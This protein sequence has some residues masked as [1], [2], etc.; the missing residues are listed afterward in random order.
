MN[1]GIEMATRCGAMTKTEPRFL[2]AARAAL[3]LAWLLAPLLCG[4]ARTTEA[5]S[6]ET[7]FLQRCSDDCGPGLQ[8]VTQICTRTCENDTGCKGLG[9]ATS[10]EALP[11]SASDASAA[12]LA[13]DLVCTGDD[14]CAALASGFSCEAGR[15]RQGEST[16]PPAHDAGRTTDAASDVSAACEQGMTFPIHASDY[17]QSCERSSDC[18]GIGEGDGCDCRVLCQ[19]AAINVADEAKWRQDIAKKPASPF[20]CRCPAATF[21]CCVEHRCSADPMLCEGSADDAGL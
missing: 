6:G 17:D 20:V 1:G 18:I 13:C 10:C 14:D 12:V 11:A 16:A 8:C 4:C 3:V 9:A 15:C 2:P 19:N 5:S 7:H 21:P